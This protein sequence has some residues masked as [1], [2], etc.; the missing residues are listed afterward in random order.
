MRFSLQTDSLGL[1]CRK[2]VPCFP[3]GGRFLHAVLVLVLAPLCSGLVSSADYSR[4]LA[5]E[6][7]TSVA[8]GTHI[9][10]F[11][12]T[13]FRGRTY[14][15]EEFKEAP[16]VAIVFLGTQCPLAKLYAARV[17]E[18][19]EQYE[20]AGV[21]FL[22]VDPNVQDS[23]EMMAAFARKQKLEEIPFLKD[24]AQQLAAAVGASRTPEVC[25]LD[26]QRRLV[27]RGR[28]DDQYGIGYARDAA[29]KTELKDAIDA[30]LS[31]GAIAVAESA[32][33]GCLIGRRRPQSS[34]SSVTYARQIAR[35]VQ[36]RCL[37]CHRDGEI[38]P[39]DFSRYEDVAAWGEMMLEVIE[40][41]R[42]PPWHADPH[43]GE[44]ANDRRMPAEEQELFAQWVRSGTPL[45]D[46]S[47]LPEAP[48]FTSGW[49][50]SREP[51]VIIPVTPEP[52]KVPAKGTVQYQYFRYTL[53]F[54]EDKWIQAAEIKPGNRAV[55]HHILVF[56]RPKGTQ[57]GIQ[58]QRSFLV[59]YVPG[60]RYE[61]FPE[62]MAKRLPAGSEL[63]FQV[64]YTPIGTEQLD[65]SQLGLVF[66]D[67]RE[68][69]HEIQTSSIFD[70][71][72]RI[73]PG[74]A[75]HPVSA[76]LERPLSECQLV[77]LSPH[78]HVRGKSF[79]Y[80]AIF[81]S[82]ERQVLLDVPQ[83]DFNW[84]T[85]YKLKDWL[86]LPEGTQLLG[87]ATFDN[88]DKNLNNPDPT[89]W[90]RFGEQTWEEMMIGYF[91]VAVPIDPETGR[92]RVN[93]V[94]ALR[95]S[96]RRPNPQEIFARLD[97]N[98]DQRLSRDEIPERFRAFIEGLDTNGDGEI[99]QS[100]FR[101]PGLP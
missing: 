20:A 90:V 35:I 33:E 79:R 70:A 44:F 59:G 76:Q 37:S 39:M 18:L 52:V 73:P 88:S 60:T 6:V 58:G 95:D 28:I 94:P 56:D 55:V 3:F 2:R 50:L 98:G 27:Y 85:E 15:S 64:H 72:F 71:R 62:G 8:I 29:G 84:Q 16:A 40:D 57:G 75:A 19:Q 91:H 46:P 24:P 80:T 48:L 69:T 21:V 63:V 49:Q 54:E 47:E 5:A 10:S 86:T 89:Q 14:R 32:A 30:L 22:A 82:G 7:E 36:N 9:E 65:Q 43:Y 96:G 100:E 87:E 66:A 67:P 74:A 23:L 81:P 31:G 93:I 51:D 12:L 99:E 41:G 101:L 4:V 13:D 38:G 1:L 11:E 42:M 61:P 25:L 77:A 26:R 68:L 97:A 78:M 83:Y 53:D 34:E 45:G 17:R 92:G